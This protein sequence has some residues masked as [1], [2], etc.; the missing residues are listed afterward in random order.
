M[1]ETG[2]AG[3]EVGIFDDADAEAEEGEGKEAGKAEAADALDDCAV[4]AG[5]AP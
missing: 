5:G 3:I 2:E 4:A 1:E